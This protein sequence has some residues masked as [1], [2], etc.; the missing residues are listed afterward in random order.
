MT[1]ST[2]PK[3]PSMKL[4]IVDAVSEEDL[5]MLIKDTKKVTLSELVDKITVTEGLSSKT[6]ANGHTRMRTYT[7]LLDFYPPEEY[8]EEHNL[9]PQQIFESLPSGFG[10]HVRNEVLRELKDV[11]KMLKSDLEG[12][13]KGSQVRISK[14]AVNEHLDEELEEAR[15]RPDDVS[16]VGDGDADDAKRASRGK[17]VETYDDDSDDGEDRDLEDIEG[18]FPADEDNDDAAAQAEIDAALAARNE[19]L[20]EKFISAAKYVSRFS[21]DIKEGRSC[22]FDI[23]VRLALPHLLALLP[24][25]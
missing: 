4:P 9:T 3:T 24:R 23:Q 14:G 25:S 21:F 2:K 11:G 17:E 22:E 12:L 1:A 16:E 7:V 15:D 8:L 20:E 6:T 19:D 5:A 10:L 13:G 18:N